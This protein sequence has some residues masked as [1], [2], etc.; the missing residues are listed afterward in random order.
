MREDI[1]CPE[2]FSEGCTIVD[3]KGD[4]QTCPHLNEDKCC[5][6][7]VTKLVEARRFLEQS[8]DVSTELRFSALRAAVEKI[9][10]HLEEAEG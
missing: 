9:L 5:E 3:P 6:L 1:P 8:N 2:P 4:S 10:E 7:M